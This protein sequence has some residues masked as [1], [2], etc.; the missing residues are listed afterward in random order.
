MPVTVLG[1]IDRWERLILPAPCEPG[2]DIAP[3]LQMGDKGLE[4]LSCLSKVMLLGGRRNGIST[5]TF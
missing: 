2:T 1:T 5:S 3:I 4:Q